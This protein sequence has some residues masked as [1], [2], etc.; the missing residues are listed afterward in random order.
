MGFEQVTAS[1]SVKTQTSLTIPANA[2][3]CEVR[4]TDQ[5]IR[6]TMD[7]TTPTQTSGMTLE[8]FDPPKL[9]QI[10]DLRAIKFTRGS[11]SD[12]TLNLHYVAGRDV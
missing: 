4:A 6:Y 3:M 12:A 2:T 7:G 8:L 1:S 9:F 10:M 5:P 11:G